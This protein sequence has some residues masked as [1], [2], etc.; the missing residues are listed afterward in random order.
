MVSNDEKSGR[1]IPQDAEELE[2]SV[3]SNV[4]K[5]VREQKP[6]EDERREL[7]REHRHHL[8]R[9]TES[10]YTVDRD[11]PTGVEIEATAYVEDTYCFTCDEWVGTSGVD[12]RGTPRSKADAYYLGGAPENVLQARNSVRD[13]FDVLVDIVADTVDHIE[14]TEDAME[15]IGNEHEKVTAELAEGDDGE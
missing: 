10:A 13:H 3:S 5:W 1:A 8:V 2:N 7:L 15:F 14:T 12:L 6:D 11:A 9:T 4:R